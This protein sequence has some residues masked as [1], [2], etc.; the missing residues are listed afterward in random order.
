MIICFLL[1]VTHV[2]LQRRLASL[3]TK[4]ATTERF[5]STVRYDFKKENTIINKNDCSR[6]VACKMNPQTLSESCVSCK[7]LNST[8]VHFDKD[9][10]I[11]IDGVITKVDAAKTPEDGVCLQSYSEPSIPCNVWGE[12]VLTR[13]SPTATAWVCRCKYPN[14]F[15][16]DS[17]LGDCTVKRV[18]LNGTLGGT[19]NGLPSELTCECEVGFT[20]YENSL[21]LPMCRTARLYIDGCIKTKWEY[22]T[23]LHVRSYFQNHDVYKKYSTMLLPQSYSRGRKKFHKKTRIIAPIEFSFTRI[24]SKR[25]NELLLIHNW[26]FESTRFTRT[27]P[28]QISMYMPKTQKARLIGELEEQEKKKQSDPDFSEKTKFENI[29]DA[30]KMSY[31]GGRA[32][33]VPPGDLWYR[34]IIPFPTAMP[35]GQQCDFRSQPVDKFLDP[36]DDEIIYSSGFRSRI[37][38]FTKIVMDIEQ[39]AEQWF[40]LPWGP[41]AILMPTTRYEGLAMGIWTDAAERKDPT[42]VGDTK[43]RTGVAALT[44]LTDPNIDIFQSRLWAVYNH[45]FECW[46]Y[47]P[48]PEFDPASSEIEVDENMTAPSPNQSTDP[49][50]LKLNDI[51][52]VDSYNYERVQDFKYLFIRETKLDLEARYPLSIGIPPLSVPKDDVCGTLLLQFVD[53]KVDYSED[54]SIH[55][56]PTVWAPITQDGSTDINKLRR[57]R[58]LKFIEDDPPGYYNR[59]GM[60]KDPERRHFQSHF[61]MEDNNLVHKKNNIFKCGEIAG[62]DVIE[63][64]LNVD[65][66]KVNLGEDWLVYARAADG[67]RGPIRK[68]TK[69]PAEDVDAQEIKRARIVEL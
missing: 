42:I 55:I 4:S 26:Y 28:K 68:G 41:M 5:Y 51:L 2:L 47:T 38:L 45:K 20:V 50:D 65:D 30:L 3:S 69:R 18:C 14:I 39:D 34:D 44:G 49:W 52:Y 7:Q 6:P 24:F 36:P 21:H 23:P 60:H 40:D 66:G 8:C 53:C 57:E 19:E 27:W 48:F 29:K 15:D 9:T 59:I 35:E 17:L 54:L 43:M 61:V 62:W 12:Y 37:P 16:S 22:V 64:P 10:L 25:S 63:S 11:E 33:Y 13:V 32:L 56:N 1:L 58:L 31:V 46:F 67:S